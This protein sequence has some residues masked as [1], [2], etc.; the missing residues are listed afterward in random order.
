MAAPHIPNLRTL[1]SD[2]ARSRGQG[3]R[4]RGHSSFTSPSSSSSQ[5]PSSA[6]SP[7]ADAVVQSTDNDAAGSRLSAVR[8]GYLDDEFAQYFYKEE[9]GEEVRRFPII[10]RGRLLLRSMHTLRKYLAVVFFLL[11]IYSMYISILSKVKQASQEEARHL[12]HSLLSSSFN[13]WICSQGIMV[14]G[15]TI[16][17]INSCAL[18]YRHLRAHHRNRPPC[19]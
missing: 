1:L 4:G 10:N 8:R 5:A 6:R 18:R 14:Y 12:P 7:D 19:H 17:V 16:T 13:K 3:R 11:S 15:V 9:K 2:R